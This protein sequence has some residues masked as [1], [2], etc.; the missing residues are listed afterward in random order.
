MTNKTTYIVASTIIFATFFPV[1]SAADEAWHLNI[2]N[3]EISTITTVHNVGINRSVPT[4]ELDVNGTITAGDFV[5]DGSQLT[6]LTKNLELMTEFGNKFDKD[7]G[8]LYG[9]FS[10]T[11]S[12]AKDIF[13][14][15]SND[16]YFPMLTLGRE[17]KPCSLQVDEMHKL[18]CDPNLSGLSAAGNIN[19]GLIAQGDIEVWKDYNIV[20][21]KIENFEYLTQPVFGTLRATSGLYKWSTTPEVSFD[22]KAAVIQKAFNAAF[23]LITEPGAITPSVRAVSNYTDSK[24]TGIL[25]EAY[26]IKSARSIGLLDGSVKLG[27]NVDT[28]KN[29]SN[30]VTIGSGNSSTKLSSILPNSVVIG[31]NSPLP[32]IIIREGSQNVPG[33]VEMGRGANADGVG[34]VSIGNSKTADTGIK[35]VAIGAGDTQTLN[36]FPGSV[37]IGADSATPSLIITKLDSLGEIGEKGADVMLNANLVP[38]GAPPSFGDRVRRFAELYLL[39]NSLHIGEGENEARI[40]YDLSSKHLLIDSA[41]GVRFTAEGLKGCGE[42]GNLLQ[43]GQTYYFKMLF[44]DD[45]GN[46][47]CKGKSSIVSDIGTQVAANLKTLL[48]KIGAIDVK[49]GEAIAAIE[50]KKEESV[51]LLEKMKSKSINLIELTEKR[52]IKTIE[53]DSAKAVDAIGA[54]STAGLSA[55]EGS[56]SAGVGA[57]TV[58]AATATTAIAALVATGRTKGDDG[59]DGDK[60]DMGFPGLAGRS[61]SKTEIKNGKLA[62]IMDDQAQTRLEVGNV[63]G[64]KGAKGDT[65]RSISQADIKEGKLALIMD[66][67]AQTRLEVGNV[68]GPKG[69]KGDSGRSISRGDIK[70]GNLALIM[71]DQAQTRVEVGNVVGPQGAKGVSGRSISRSDI[72]DGKLALIMDD[73]AQTRVEVGNVVG[74]KG[75]KGDPGQSVRIETT[76]LIPELSKDC[77]AGGTR[78]TIHEGD[79]ATRSNTICNGLPARVTDLRG[80]VHAKRLIS[81]VLQLTPSGRPENPTNGTIYFDKNSKKFYAYADQWQELAFVGSGS[82]FNRSGYYK[83]VFITSLEYT[84]DLGG[85]LGANQKCQQ[86]ASAA[87]LKGSYK[88]WVSTAESDPSRTFSRSA[89]PYIRT[90]GV[91]IAAN[92]QGL[93]T[94]QF[95][96]NHDE[97]GALVEN[98]LAWTSTTESGL[99]YYQP[100]GEPLN[101]CANWTSG[102]KE[103][104]GLAG[105]TSPWSTEGKIY[106][107]NTGPSPCSF[108]RRLFCFEQ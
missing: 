67:Q 96:I 35:S 91:K 17:N 12:Q 53:L 4:S 15:D 8:V 47:G 45:D 21:A 61:I 3:D 16:V 9:N 72:K 73:Q 28:S 24:L 95:T 97:N 80:T 31:A 7:G 55:I 50:T 84:G 1:I 41:G 77:P 56:R 103:A 93:P 11:N 39:P 85:I 37:V 26:S 78:L 40:G 30:S 102:S 66:D 58:A 57:I 86:L 49:K 29:V 62:L 68:V 108:H 82:S 83:T 2:K 32:S 6:N 75:A 27:A 90:D 59:D 105:L 44:V 92:W 94:L 65:G 104:E 19:L 74:P 25:T 43:E 14:V 101:N 64:P 51:A 23:G 87:E 20:L 98:T 18:G 60:G 100:S 13:Q 70:D 36:S 48:P 46:L 38:V 10:F 106:W 76:K 33:S 42:E 79:N 69:A 34:S 107:S 63:V 54:S 5:G 81:D 52:S 99:T 22:T 71:D 89:V 88:A